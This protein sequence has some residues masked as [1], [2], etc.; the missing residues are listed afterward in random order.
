MMAK[1]CAPCGSKMLGRRSTIPPGQ[2][3]EWR[4]FFPKGQTRDYFTEADADTA[5]DKF[6]GRKQKLSR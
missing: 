3:K 2:R 5:I 6:G 4:V 1:P